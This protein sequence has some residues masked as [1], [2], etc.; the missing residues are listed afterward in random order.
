MGHFYFYIFVHSYLYTVTMKYFTVIDYIFGPIILILIVILAR[1]KKYRKL[2]AHPEYAYFTKGIYAKL[3]GGISFLMIYAIYYGEGDTTNYYYDATC[4]VRLMLKDFPAFWKI[5]REGL[6][7]T[8]Y[9][10]F[11]DY[12]G[13]PIYWRGDIGTFWVVRVATF[14]VVISAGSIVVST[15][16]FAAISFG[17]AWQLY[18]L[19]ISEFPTLKKEMAI[20][21]FFIPSVFFW[22]SGIM[23]D[24]ITLACVGYYSF[25]VHS[26]LIKREKV[27]WNLV[28]L[29]IASFFI[30]KIKPYIF[31]ALVPGTVIWVISHYSST[32]QN[33]LIRVLVGPIML[34]L[35]IGGGYLILASMSE[36]LGNYS[37][38]DVLERAVI[39]N[40]DL[41]ADYYAGNSFDIGDF[42][43]TISSMLSKAPAAINVA[44]F[45]P[46]LWEAK[47]IVMF[48]SGTEGLFILTFTLLILWR[49]RIIGL[50]LNLSKSHL[51]VFSLIFSIF[52]AFSVGISTSNFGSLVRYRIPAL[53]FFVASLF[54]LDYYEKEKRRIKEQ[55]KTQRPFGS[56]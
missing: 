40:T 39:T 20:A 48:I 14:V 42:D 8:N 15:L 52:F 41:K 17:G 1:V 36:L 27:F 43:P 31:F 29:I 38:D 50:F 44:L 56:D 37:V 30:I 6:N 26:A 11:D 18:R 33:K 21:I 13:W 7:I 51:L 45:R 53:P 47:N 9:F 55:D 12:T 24:T 23:K 3:L 32:I 16:I 25:S 35:A 19:F 10:F 4:M 46:Y 22:G 28:V 5:M 2:G 54:I 34:V 49:I